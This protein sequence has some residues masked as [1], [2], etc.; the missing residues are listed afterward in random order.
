L[1]E[2]DYAQTLAD[3]EDKKGRGTADTSHLNRLLRK[4]L[5]SPEPPSYKLRLNRPAEKMHGH[6]RSHRR[7]YSL[8]LTIFWQNPTKQDD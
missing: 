7:P 3:L 5:F 6:L 4:P 2:N 8:I 1:R